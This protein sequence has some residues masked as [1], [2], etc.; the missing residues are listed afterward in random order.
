[1]RY[2]RG[3]YLLTD[4][5]IMPR[6]RPVSN[7]LE[8]T[9]EQIASLTQIANSRSEELRRV[10]RAKVFLAA[11]EGR[12][13]REIADSVGLS[14]SAVARMIRKALQIGPMMAL[15]DLKRSG[16]PI[17]IGAEARTW[18]KELAC[19]PPKELP[20]GPTQAL[21]SMDT[22]AEYVRQHAADMPFGDELTKASKSTIW[23]IL[24]DDAIKPHR[25]RYYLEKKDPDFSAKCREVLLLYKRVEM[26][27]ALKDTLETS[28]Q[29]NCSVFVSYD[30]KPGIQAIG[31]IHPDRAP[32]SGK[33]FIRRDYEYKRHGTLSLL[34]GIDLISGKVHSLIRERHKSS[35]FIDFLKLIDAA[36]PADAVIYMVLD[37]HTIHT[38]RETRA[39]LD[40]RKGRF[41]FVFTP[42]HASWLNLIEAF[43]SK[44]VRMSLRGLRVNSKEELRAHIER[45]VAECNEDPVPFRWRWKM[46]EVHELIGSVI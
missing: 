43:F 11:A 28:S 36:Y 37:N 25:I 15:D 6:G 35:D 45:W 23:A 2:N 33:G 16:R 8:L 29:P 20:D 41:Q 24:D 22:L 18:V 27:I 30:E 44:M 1:M 10:Q 32:K 21:W 4:T 34:A 38:S 42:K 39:F 14:L 31:N 3:T 19:T 9:A 12:P 5:S 17:V 40:N 26:Q 13:Q 46:D 7:R